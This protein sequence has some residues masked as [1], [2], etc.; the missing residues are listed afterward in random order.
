MMRV[1]WLRPTVL[2]RGSRLGLPADQARKLLAGAVAGSPAQRLLDAVQVC[3]GNL[4]AGDDAALV[5][6]L[7]LV[8][9]VADHGD[10]LHVLSFGV[11]G[12]LGARTI[13]QVSQSGHT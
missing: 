7:G 8:C 1:Y 6:S 2:R 12:V 5:L 3:L 10:G 13:A 9:Q 11:D 4:V